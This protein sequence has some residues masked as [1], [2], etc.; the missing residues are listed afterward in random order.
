MPF[1]RST[2]EPHPEGP[3]V[4]TFVDFKDEEG[5]YGPQTRVS[6]D[7]EELMEDGRPF[8]IA[9]WITEQFN[10]RSN[11]YKFLKAMGIDVDNIEDAELEGLDLNDLIGRRCQLIIEHIKR[12]DA[13][14]SAKVANL[15]SLKKRQP[16]KPE[17]APEPV[18]AATGARSAAKWVD[19]ED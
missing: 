6:F 2:F 3:T 17:P 11:A 16:P 12:P 4:G 15:L 1:K 8:R 14:I 19:D 10:P 13:T 18:R 7:T 5:K 9:Y